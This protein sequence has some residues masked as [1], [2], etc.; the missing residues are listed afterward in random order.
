MRCF[1]DSCG[2]VFPV[3]CGPHRLE[4]ELGSKQQTER[5]LDAVPQL[6]PDQLEGTPAEMSGNFDICRTLTQ[7]HNLITDLERTAR[8]LDANMLKVHTPRHPPKIVEMCKERLLCDV[9]W[10][11]VRGH[12][13]LQL[14][15]VQRKA[16]NLSSSHAVTPGWH[17]VGWGRKLGD[18][19]NLRSS[20]DSH[21]QCLS[22]RPPVTY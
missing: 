10:W 5:Q 4:A 17:P 16:A 12:T 11:L 13:T 9:W 15:G 2:I 14:S 7:L 21:S 19:R 22:S 6:W 20:C 18:D 1:C 3:D 8:E